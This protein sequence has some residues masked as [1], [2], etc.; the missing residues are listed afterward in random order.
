[1]IIKVP[2]AEPLDKEL[3][4]IFYQVRNGE[5]E[6]REKAT[7][8]IRAS[9]FPICPKAIHINS[10]LAYRHRPGAEDTFLKDSTASMGT[11]VHAALQKWFGIK[12]PNYLYG[13]WVCKP[14]KKIRRHCFGIQDCKICGEEMVYE[15]FSIKK[16]KLTP[17]TGH[18]D[19]LMVLPHGNF[20]IDFKGSSLEAMRNLASDK[21]PY[22]K[23]YCQT[24]A[25]A[26]A[27]EDPEQ[28]LGII[29]HIDKIVIIYLRRDKPQWDWTSLQVPVSK[30]IYRDTLSYLREGQISLE[31][32]QVPRGFCASSRDSHARFCPFKG[33]CFSPLLETMLEDEV[34]PPVKK[35]RKSI[36][37]MAMS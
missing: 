27:I 30:R 14:C 29:D 37:E 33:V 24:N 9:S 31:K 12:A 13:N 5:R 10:R 22:L 18:I 28:D 21:R 19:G 17:F 7:Q 11:A 32:L 6:L 8:E 34:L 16:T 35:K 23:H 15:E 20:L 4:R 26:N 3:K 2:K 1:M 36:L 25:Y